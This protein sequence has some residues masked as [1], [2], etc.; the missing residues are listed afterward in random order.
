MKFKTQ[1][2]PEIE[3]WS[4]ESSE[5]N[6]LFLHLFEFHIQKVCEIMSWLVL[7]FQLL[8]SCNTENNLAI[9]TKYK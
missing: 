6:L 5:E 9:Y 7:V 1:S 2:V 4:F 8:V 3:N